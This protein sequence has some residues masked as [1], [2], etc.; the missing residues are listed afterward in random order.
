MVGVRSGAFSSSMC[1]TL[2][3]NHDHAHTDS[4]QLGMLEGHRTDARLAGGYTGATAHDIV[5]SIDP[6]LV[7]TSPKV[8]F[9]DRQ[10]R[11]VA[12]SPL[13]C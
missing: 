12:K 11:V 10:F 8:D 5:P 7:N 6:P 13:V 2:G 9:I 4:F 3:T 1:I